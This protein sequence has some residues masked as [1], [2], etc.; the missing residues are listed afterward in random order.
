M[1][2]WP[3]F[4]EL[5][6]YSFRQDIAAW[7]NQVQIGSMSK[8]VAQKTIQNFF[9]R[10]QESFKILNGFTDLVKNCA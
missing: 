1:K 6:L 10:S 3:A 5:T 9:K 8:D 2:R 7:S 4:G